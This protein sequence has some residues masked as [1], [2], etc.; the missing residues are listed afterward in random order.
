MRRRSFG[1]SGRVRR[2]ASTSS[3]R[4]IS[5]ARAACCTSM[6]T[7]RLR[8]RTSRRRRPGSS[9]ARGTASR[10]RS[11]RPHPA[12]DAVTTASTGQ[13]SFK[14][15]RFYQPGLL[16]APE[17]WLWEGL[18]SG[19]TSAKSFSLAGVNAA[20]SQAAVLEVF[21][22]GASESGNT[23]DHHV[24][25]SVNGTLAGEAQFAG[26]TAYRMSLAC[27]SRSCTREPTSSRS[28]TWRTP[29]CRPTS[30]WT[31]SRSPTRRSRRSRAGCSKGRGPRV[32]RRRSRGRPQRSST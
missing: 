27:Q 20:S 2:R 10:C 18:A 23:I 11:S 16:E 22:Q 30:S 5:S 6:P 21:L 15:N 25:V 8:R 26:K 19:M 7:P 3:P 9:C 28:R 17:L 32:G 4:G 1:S 24:S 13:A 31:A 12:G 29:G 14:M